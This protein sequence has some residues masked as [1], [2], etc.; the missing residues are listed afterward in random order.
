[1]LTFIGIY[2]CLTE[3]EMTD[4]E[5]KKEHMEGLNH[6][7]TIFDHIL[8][9]IKYYDRR[10]YR[11][12]AKKLDKYLENL[13]K[14]DRNI[15]FTKSIFNDTVGFMDGRILTRRC[16]CQICFTKKATLDFLKRYGKIYKNNISIQY[17]RMSDSMNSN[18]IGIYKYMNDVRFEM[19]YKEIESMEWK[20][21]YFF[22]F[23][24]LK[25]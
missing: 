18:Y 3:D 9:S 23:F 22:V 8:D 16:P 6:L 2:E 15:Y 20:D 12:V 10:R 21:N 11:S 7:G 13:E 1:M 4:F 5:N 24:P 17:T 19:I 25:I 14:E